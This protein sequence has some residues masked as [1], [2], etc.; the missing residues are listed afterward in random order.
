MEIHAHFL[1]NCVKKKNNNQKEQKKCSALCWL[2]NHRNA[3]RIKVLRN[4]GQKYKICNSIISFKKKRKV[5]LTV[6]KLPEH[7]SYAKLLPPMFS[8]NYMRLSALAAQSI[9]G[10]SV[11][12]LPSPKTVRQNTRSSGNASIVMSHRD[13]LVSVAFQTGGSINKASV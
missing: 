13:C 11:A 8:K 6:Q 12:L 10:S 3:P 1:K 5:W 2:G 9:F 7:L 4:Y